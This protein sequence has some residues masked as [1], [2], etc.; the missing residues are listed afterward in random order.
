VGE[1]FW[2]VLWF[3]FPSRAMR[4]RRCA[5]AMGRVH[6][7]RGADCRQGLPCAPPRR[8]ATMS[9]ARSSSLTAACRVSPFKVSW[10]WASETCVMCFSLIGALVG[11]AGRTLSVPDMARG[12]WVTLAP[13]R[14]GAKIRWGTA[15]SSSAADTKRKVGDQLPGGASAQELGDGT[16]AGLGLLVEAVPCEIPLDTNQQQLVAHIVPI[17]PWPRGVISP[18]QFGHVLQSAIGG[19]RFGHSALKSPMNNGEICPPAQFGCVSR[20]RHTH[21][22][23]FAPALGNPFPAVVPTIH[24]SC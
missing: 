4:S 17:A 23:R 20:G 13:G 12:E 7:P 11:P 1:H 10:E 15:R 21:T 2:G 6:T 22:R 8:S 16:Q 18:A 24:R 14:S 3:C 5:T 19:E 9:A